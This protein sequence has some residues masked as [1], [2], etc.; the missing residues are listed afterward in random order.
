MQLLFFDLWKGTRYSLFYVLQ[1]IDG[2]H[3]KLII[4]IQT[5]CAKQTLLSNKSFH[6]SFS[7]QSHLYLMKCLL[8]DSDDT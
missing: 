8:F 6:M 1:D 4:H 3:P 7:T 5:K 2:E